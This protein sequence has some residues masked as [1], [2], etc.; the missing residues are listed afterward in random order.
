MNGLT[1]VLV[2]FLLGL[3]KSLRPYKYPHHHPWSPLDGLIVNLTKW[4]GNVSA[5]VS[6]LKSGINTSHNMALP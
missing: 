4:S 6:A 1:G 2:G 3:S 5:R